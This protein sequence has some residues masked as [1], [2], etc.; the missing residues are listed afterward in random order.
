[1]LYLDAAERKYIEEVAASNVFVVSDG[2]VHTPALGTILPG[3]TRRSVIELLQSEMGMEVVE[4]QLEIRTA[5]HD[6]DEAFCVGTGASVAPIG[7]ITYDKEVVEYTVGDSG[8]GQVAQRVLGL[9]S[10]IQSGAIEDTRGWIHH[11]MQ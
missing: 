1:M 6:A 2:V 8:F 11:V 3:V 5:M 9:L 4:G 10:G 7:S